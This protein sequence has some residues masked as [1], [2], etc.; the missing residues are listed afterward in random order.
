MENKYNIKNLP[1]SAM[2]YEY[3]LGRLVGEDVYYYGA[4]HNL[5]RAVEVAS[6]IN[7]IVF[8]NF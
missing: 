1:E 4:D 5:Q 8:A 3:I 2:K 6:R 7:G